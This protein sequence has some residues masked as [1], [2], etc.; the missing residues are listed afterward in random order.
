M[1]FLA[2]FRPGINMRPEGFNH[3]WTALSRSMNRHVEDTFE[4]RMHGLHVFSCV[5]ARMSWATLK[6]RLCVNTTH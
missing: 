2:L 3:K 5:Y 4:I 6:D 1:L